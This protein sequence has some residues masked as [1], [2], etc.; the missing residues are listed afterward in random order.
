MALRR[1]LGASK[2][3][4]SID[5]AVSLGAPRAEGPFSACEVLSTPGRAAGARRL[6]SP[7]A[8]T[9]PAALD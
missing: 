3:A 4:G 8:A 7:L 6:P 5:A 2:A 9:C 1:P